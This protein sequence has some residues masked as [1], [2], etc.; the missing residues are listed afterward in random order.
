VERIID[1]I[2]YEGKVLENLWDIST[3]EVAGHRE[4]SARRAVHW[5]ELGPA[6][7]DRSREGDGYQGAPTKEQLLKWA[8]EDA[9]ALLEEQEANR[10]KSAAKAKTRA[11]H[12]MKLEGFDEMLTLTYR[13]NMQDFERSQKHFKEWVR[14]MKKA[15][16]TFRYCAG[17]E[18]QERGAIHWH[19]STHKLP[20]LALYKGVKVKAWEVG[21][22]IWRDIIGSVQLHGPMRLGENRPDLPGGLCFVGGKP[23]D[24]R[25]KRRRNMSIGKIAAYVSKYIQKNCLDRPAEK[26][27]YSRS[28]ALPDT[29]G[30]VVG[31]MRPGEVRNRFNVPAARPVKSRMRVEGTLSEVVAKV[32]TLSEGDTIVSHRIG[33]WKDSYWLVTEPLTDAMRYRPDIE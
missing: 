13:E 19:V 9:A 32:F 27:R 21:T 29:I 30:E 12:F 23:R 28:N 6:G 20:K 1:G 22:K 7:I 14:R 11:R 16:G 24:P 18:P 10:K 8:K 25:N 4:I 15:L 17:W 2:R 26:N 31:P 3:V 33:P 5:K